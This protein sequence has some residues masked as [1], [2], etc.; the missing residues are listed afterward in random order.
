MYSVYIRDLQILTSSKT[1]PNPK[2][3]K[4]GHRRWPYMR[5]I[6]SYRCSILQSFSAEPS[7]GVTSNVRTLHSTQY[8]TYWRHL[9]LPSL[10]RCH[11]QVGSSKCLQY[12][13]FILS[14]MQS[15]NVVPIWP[16]PNICHYFT[17]IPKKLVFPTY[18]ID[19]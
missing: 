10:F 16:N 19:R 9:E 4:N 6:I 15:T 5:V 7:S 3:E 1:F 12:V 17:D 18:T 14:A 8:T 2:G 13:V 11:F